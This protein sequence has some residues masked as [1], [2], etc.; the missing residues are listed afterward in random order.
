M[1]FLSDSLRQRMG[2]SPED[3]NA[4]FAFNKANEEMNKPEPE[5]LGTLGQIADAY[6]R[7]ARC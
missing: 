6:V 5:Q 7:N 2:Q 3:Y 4:A 1:S